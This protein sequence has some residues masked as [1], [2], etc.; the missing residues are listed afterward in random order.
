MATCLP[1]L[2][3]L[4]LPLT[5][6]MQGQWKHHWAELATSPNHWAHAKWKPGGEG[7]KAPAGQLGASARQAQAPRVA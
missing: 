7:E 4:L 5:Q 1:K 6:Q 3:L 2:V